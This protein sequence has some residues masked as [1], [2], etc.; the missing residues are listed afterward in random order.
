MIAARPSADLTKKYLPLITVEELN[1]LVKSSAAPR[2]AFVTISVPEGQPVIKDERRQGRS[3]PRSRSP[4][5][6]RGKEK[7]IRRR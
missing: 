2:T 3:S 6:R 1:G 5:S 4:T 7:P